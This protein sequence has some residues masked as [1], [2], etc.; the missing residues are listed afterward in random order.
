MVPIRN[1][2]GK[3]EGVVAGAGLELVQ[4][5][6]ELLVGEKALLDQE[7][8]ERLEPALVVGRVTVLAVRRRDLLDQLV[9]KLVPVEQ[10]LLV[11]RDRQAEDARLPGRVEHELAV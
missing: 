8:L 11:H 5:R 1:T 6:G 10:L 9:T 7:M 4:A 2:R 3:S